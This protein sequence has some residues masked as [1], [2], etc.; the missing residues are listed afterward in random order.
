[1]TG[2]WVRSTPTQ[3]C[4]SDPIPLAA[5]IR[6]VKSRFLRRLVA[7][8]SSRPT[9]ASARRGKRAP[10]P[11]Q[12]EA[13]EP[14]IV[15]AGEPIINEFMA[16]NTST[17]ADEEGQFVDWIEIYNRGDAAV[18][19]DGW[20]LTDD[21]GD[22]TKWRFPAEILDPGEY[23]VVFASNKDRATVGQRLHTNFRLDNDG[24]LLALVHPDGQTV[25]SAFTPEFPDQIANVSYGTATDIATFPMV[26]ATMDGKVLVPT[27]GTLGTSWVAPDFNDAAW[28]N[29]ITGVG[30]V[31]AP[32]PPFGDYI[33]TDLEAQIY[34]QRAGAYLRVPFDLASLPTIDSLK[35]HMRYDDGFVAYLNGVEIARSNVAPGTPAWNATASSNRPDD[36]ATTF[37]DFDV[38][39]FIDE[40]VEGTNVLAIHGLNSSVAASDTGFLILPELVGS[41]TIGSELAY[42][43]TPTPGAANV[44]GFAGLGEGPTFSTATGT[45][46]TNFSLSLSTGDPSAV[47]RYTVNGSAPT[48]S[49]PVYS[50]PIP[51]TTTTQVRARSFPVGGLPS[52]IVSH[53][54]YKLAA[55][56]QGFNSNLPIVVIDNFGQGAISQNTAQSGYMAIFEP[57]ESG[58]TQITDLP[59]TTSRTGMRIRGSSTAGDPK[60]QYK[61]ETWDDQNDDRDVSILGM[62]AESDWV[63]FAS[64]NFDRAMMRNDF[65]YQLSNE[66]GQYAVRTRFVEVFLNTGGGELNQGDYIGVYSFMESIKRDDD[67]V[68]IDRLLPG[69]TTAPDV[70]GGYMVKIDRCDPGDSGFSAANQGLCFVEPNETTLEQAAWDPQEQYIRSYINQFGTALNGANFTNPTTGYAAFFDADRSID[71]HLLNVLAMNVDALRLST[72]LYK[73]RNGKLTFGPIWDFDRSMESTDGRDDNP[74]QWNGPPDSTIYFTSDSRNIWWGRLF[75]DPNFWQKWIDRWQELRETTLSTAHMHAILDANRDY[76]AEA[77][78]RNFTRWSAAP[79]RGGSHAAEVN[80]MKNWLATRAAWIDGRFTRKATLSHPGG[81]VAQGFQVTLSGPA[82][83]TLYYTT[84]GSDPRASG[85]GISPTALVYSG[86]ITI[87]DNTR[88]TVRAKSATQLD[89][90]TWSGPRTGDYFTDP[91]ALAVSEIHYNPAPPSVAEIAA[92][93]ASADDFEFLEVQNVRD[94]PLNLAGY[95]FS[96][97]VEFTFGNVTLQPGDRAVVVRNSAAFSARYG[98]GIVPVGQYGNVLPSLDFQLANDG[99][100]IVLEGPFGNTVEDF[101]YADNWYDLTDG[102]GFSLVSV[103]PANTAAN[104]SLAASWR[105]SDFENGSPGAGDIG[106][107]PQAGAIILSEALT[108]TASPS[109]D[110][111]ELRNTTAAPIDLQHWYASDDETNLRKFRFTASTIVPA[112]GY[113][114]VGKN[115]LG[116]AFDLSSLGGTLIVQAANASDQL[117]GFREDRQFGGAD[118]ETTLGRVETSDGDVDFATLATATP[119]ADNASPVI[120]PVV[121]NEIMYH[122]DNAAN[123]LVEDEYIELHNTTAAAIPLYDPANPANTWQISG[124]GGFAFPAGTTIPA[125]GYVVVTNADPFLFRLLYNVPAAVE[126]YQFSGGLNNAGEAIDLL[127]PATPNAQGVPYVIADHVDYGDSDPWPALADGGGSSLSRFAPLDYGNEPN[128]WLPSTIGGTPG[129]TNT[130]YDTT[131]PTVPTNLAALAAGPAQ[132]DLAWT[133]SVDPQSAVLRYHVF[134]NGELIGTPATNAFADTAAA[135]GIEYVYEVSAVNLDLAESAKSAAS[136]P[137]ALLAATAVVAPREHQLR[138]VFSEPVTAASA[139]NVA[140]YAIPGVQVLA[141]SLGGTGKTVL[142]TTTSID[143]GPQYAL[144]IANIV[145]TSGRTLAPNSVHPFVLSGLLEQFAVRH[146]SAAGTQVNNLAAA[147][148]LLGLPSG[149]PGIAGEATANPSTIDYKDDD[150][151]ADAGRFPGSSPFPNNLPGNDNDFAVR[152]SGTITVPEGQAGPWT[153]AAGIIGPQLTFIAKGDTWKFLDNGT[154]QGTAWRTLA[155]NDAAWSTGAAELGYGDGDEAT[156]ISFGPSSSA[157]YITTYFRKTFAVENPAAIVG[158]TMQLKRDDGAAV[159]LNGTEI[160][161]DN[162]PAG[163]LTYTT[164]APAAAGDDGATF[165]TFTV[166]TNLLVAGDNVLAVEIHQNGGGSSDV[167]FDLSLVGDTEIPPTPPGGSVIFPRGSTWKYLDNGSNQGTAWRQPGFND[168]TW[169]SGPAE[170]GYGDNDEETVV[171]FGPNSGNKYPTTYFRTAFNVADASQYSTLKF[172]VQRDDGVAVYLNGVE[173]VRDGLNAGALFSDFATIT[174]GGADETTFFEFNVDPAL[175]VT[176]QNVIAAEVHQVNATSSDLGFDLEVVAGG[177][178]SDDGA[179]VVI[180]GIPV[181]VADSGASRIDRYGTVNLAEGE[182]TFELVF[183]ERSGPAQ[184]ELFAAPGTH[185]S[186]DESF[187]R[188]GDV[189][190]GGLSIVSPGTP[191]N[192]SPFV[193]DVLVAS[194][195]WSAEYLAALASAGLGGGGVS[196]ARGA[197]QLA[198][199]SWT[200]LDQVKIRFSDDM[201]VAE[202]DLALRG[203]NVADYVATVGLAPGGFGYD[204]VTRTATWTF[205]QSFAADKLLVELAD[206]ATDSQGAPLDGEWTDAASTFSGNGTPGG[207]FRFRFDVLPGDVNASGQVTLA[208]VHAN[209]AAQFRSLGHAQYDPQQDVDGNGHINATDLVLVRNHQ[210]ASLPAGEPAPSASPTAAAG[211][212]VVATKPQTNRETADVS[213]RALRTRKLAADAARRASSRI[214]VDSAA[215][216]SPSESPPRLYARRPAQTHATRDAALRQLFSN[217]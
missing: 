154:D 193:T 141:A 78:V 111:L 24:E 185:V 26:Q 31:A 196:L 62:P 14:R 205:D 169:A 198:P 106:L 148:A 50:A 126:I 140:N 153:F 155:F 64:Y 203:V 29:A 4:R 189:A 130:Y 192:E 113:L 157:K 10:R 91:F 98:A 119:S 30:Y 28:Q 175:L 171:G 72:Y 174:V 7:P 89:G 194:S 216:P 33:Q 152:A 208:D 59:T 138:V 183:F 114:V 17:L 124:I 145:G 82:G 139:E 142:L 158:L 81:T 5:R 60:A 149:H 53:T 131:P 164:N 209:R 165:L 21:Q 25:A 181:F 84:D 71:H 166:P 182:H 133:A 195:A 88:I 168:A 121:V 67:R 156:V 186:F 117:L 85:G 105:T 210:I 94:R 16:E 63:L 122:P 70:T 97:G 191:P 15:L 1:M 178:V 204:A 213:V 79:P 57:G 37:Q 34:Q 104:D 40:L 38:S 39:G 77:A 184:L 101:R 197:A 52:P 92:G 160:A 46:T 75:Q 176:G 74:S 44:V 162:L 41:R 109:G 13:L 87:N 212:I 190:S 201:L 80:I 12:L 143:D 45:F 120:G 93:Y 20:F 6:P 134:R 76:L 115:E 187:R 35:L 179:R 55:D 132:I 19:L 36:S 206:T 200:N 73:P 23:L 100:R 99:E 68:D 107:A 167:S 108:N 102:E 207:D 95:K 18:N 9:Q 199:V 8:R 161:R 215:T 11:F 188:I 56:V 151:A 214:L 136:A 86:P 116:P 150:G 32:E 180:D 163:T 112:G 211:A 137:L 54:F 69:D 65:I 61:L 128:N 96:S 90:S 49:S 125:G 51:I 159:Y 66:I 42:M 172:R 170:L 129:R 127:R 3:A 43:S 110:W 118:A 217:T 83:T 2:R 48:A 147:D 173:V 47:I 202:T 58:R 177:A 144:T 22:L 135:P 146:V 103:D 27:S 123:P